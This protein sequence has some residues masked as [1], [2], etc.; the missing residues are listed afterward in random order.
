MSMAA[1]VGDPAAS[2]YTVTTTTCADATAAKKE[3][4][5]AAENLIFL[6]RIEKGMTRVSKKK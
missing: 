1:V 4:R 5:P 6:Q 2:A 3:N